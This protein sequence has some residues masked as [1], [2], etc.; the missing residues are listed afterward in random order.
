[1]VSAGRTAVVVVDMQHDFCHPDGAMAQLGFDVSANESIV[2]PLANFL[3]RAR[4]AGV[5]VIYLRQSASDWTSSPAR[6]ARAEAMGR[7]ANAVCATGSWGA[8]IH[9]ALAPHD[10]DLVIDKYRYSGFVGGA[11][12]LVLRSREVDTVVVVGT[13][14]N[15]CVDSTAR[16]AFM[17]DFSVV[18]A[19]DLVGHT[20]RD[21]AEAALENLGIYFATVCRSDEIV[22]HW[23]LRERA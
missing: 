16:D 22:A 9:A 10:D 13:A 21:L 20:R 2:E 6:R 18:V 23:A 5:S 19:R 7:S 15:V 4:G 8:E 12:E 1:M 3:D 11:L 17:R 14:A